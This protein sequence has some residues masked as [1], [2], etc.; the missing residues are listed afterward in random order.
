MSEQKPPRYKPYNQPAG[1]W[2]AAGATAKV[3]LQQSVIGKGSKALLAMNQP[4]GFKCPSCAFP[5][6]DERRKLEFCENGAKALAWEATRFRADRE[7]FARY[8]VS[9]LMEVKPPSIAIDL[10]ESTWGAGGHY[11]VWMNPQ[12]EFMWPI[13][14]RCE[15]RMEALVKRFPEP[16]TELVGRALNQAARELLLLEGSDW[17]FLVTT[18]QAK[19]YAIDRF[20][21][22]VERFET[23]ADALLAGA[24]TEELVSEIADIDNAFADIDYRDFRDRQWSASTAS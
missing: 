20:T 12:V 8:T 21:E 7:L 4:G 17:P 11:K 13:I 6:A 23:L 15:T 9:E 18:G 22:H 2:G 3:L 16:P 1:G 5:D 24:V 19:A 14:H 10:P